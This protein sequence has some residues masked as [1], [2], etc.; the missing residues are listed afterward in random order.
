MRTPKLREIRE[1]LTSLFSKPYTIGYPYA[2]S[3]P[4]ERFRGKPKFTEADCIGCGACAQVCPARAIE[5]VNEVKDGKGTRTLTIHHDHC[6]FCGQCN[7]YCTVETGVVLTGDFET[8]TYDRTTA[9]STIEKELVIC[10]ECG[11]VIGTVDQIRWVADKL[12]TKAFGNMS[13]ALSLSEG[14]GLVTRGSRDESRALE[15]GD[16]VSFLCPKCRRQVILVEE[17]GP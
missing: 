6:I 2:P 5:V 14:L 17:W 9:V 1:A 11:E 4:P 7:R 10:Q 8:G 15:R 3:V 13:L 16:N 12:G